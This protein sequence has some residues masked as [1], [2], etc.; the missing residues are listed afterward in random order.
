MEILFLGG[1]K[2]YL[3]MM[4]RLIKKGYNV[5]AVGFTSAKDINKKVNHLTLKQLNIGDY[6]IIVLP[7]SGINLQNQIKTMDGIM[8]INPNEF[9]NCKDN[10]KIY[11]GLNNLSHL[12]I[13][14][15][16]IQSFLADPAV[17]KENNIITVKGIIDYIKNQDLTKVCILGYGNIGKMLYD[18]FRLND[19]NVKVGV[20][21]DEDYLTLKDKSFFTDNNEA[22]QNVFNS[23]TLIIN[24]VPKNIIT[25]E[26]LDKTN[27]HI[28]D[29]ASKPFGVNQ[30]VL[31]DFKHYNYYL[32]SGI[33]SV[34]APLQAGKILSK[35]LEEEIKGGKR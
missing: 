8:Y 26:L 20:I 28:L 13:R 27:A 25:E 24:T 18:Y 22:M 34:Y 9:Y 30:A 4:D 35:K 16:N 1:D 3:V 11:T 17:N 15:K 7:I 14:K 10:C 19:I 12:P 5:D 29:I 6:N 23:S 2:R 33:P 21:L 32:Y 31:A